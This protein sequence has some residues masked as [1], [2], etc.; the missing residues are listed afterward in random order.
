MKTSRSQILHGALLATSALVGSTLLTSNVAMAGGPTGGTVAVGSATIT[1]PSSTQTIINQSSK[2]AFIDWNSFSISSGSSVVFNQPNSKSLT[3]NR[4]TGPNA[5]AIDGQLSANGNIW[6]LNANGVLFGRGSE[7]NVGALLATT[8]DLSDDDFRK[9]RYNF[10]KPSQ[11]ANASIDNQGTIHAANGGSVVLSGARVS[12]EGLIQADLGT[13]VL[14]GAS[15]FTVDMTGDNLLRYQITAPVGAA[16]RDSK[17]NIAAALVSNSGTISASGGKILMTARAARNVEDNAINNTGMVEATSVSSRDG[18]IIFDA[19]PDGTVNA[20]GTVDASGRAPGQTGGSVSM[21]GGTVN[22]ADGA[23]VDASGDQGG[24]SIQIGGGF[25]GQGTIANSNAT[26]IGNASIK[27][28]AITSGNGGKVAVWSNGNTSFAGTISAKGGVNGG[29]GGFVE[30]SGSHVQLATSAGVN[31]TA[32]KGATGN[33]LLD[34]TDISIV[35]G[36]EDGIGTTNAEASIDPNTIINALT[37]SNVTLEASDTI[38]VLMPFSII[39]PTR[40]VCSPAE[41]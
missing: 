14:G 23:K 19:G 20:G 27:A 18:E 39:A 5:S 28:D 4:V 30:T 37:T 2:K 12:N 21:T 25:H 10:S 6:L 34:P 36:G 26:N 24:G 22:V 13:V 3:V 16:P 32:K 38:S 17:G 41:A 1:N 40:S 8:S 9:G 33:W 35:Q 15:T 7:V 31:T 11:N 29:N